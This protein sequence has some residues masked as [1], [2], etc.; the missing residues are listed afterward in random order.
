VRRRRRRSCCGRRIR[1]A[2]LFIIVL[3]SRRD[4]GPRQR[5]IAVI[6]PG[7]VPNIDINTVDTGWLGA[8]QNGPSPLM[9]V[10]YTTCLRDGFFDQKQTL[11]TAATPSW[12]TISIQVAS[13]KT[14]ARTGTDHGL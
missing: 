5:P 8:H 7:Y 13:V 6:P 10:L 2:Y 9:A 14:R 11:L 4:V 3:Q 12:R 1:N